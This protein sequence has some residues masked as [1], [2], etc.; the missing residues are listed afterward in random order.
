LIHL[1]SF[2]VFEE[3]LICRYRKF[4]ERHQV[5]RFAP[6]A[7]S[8]RRSSLASLAGRENEFYKRIFER[9]VFARA[10][11]CQ[12]LCLSRLGRKLNFFEWISFRN[13]D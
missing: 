13:S 12:R 7:V 10:S 1:V 3:S 2:D 5:L 8:Y 4:I 6:I 9:D 11:L